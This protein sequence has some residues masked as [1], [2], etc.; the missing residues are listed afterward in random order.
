MNESPEIFEENRLK[1]FDIFD[2]QENIGENLNFG[3]GI[4]LPLVKKLTEMLG[5]CIRLESNNNGI[6]FFVNIPTK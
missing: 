5:G 1:I 6:T 3:L 2:K 4:G